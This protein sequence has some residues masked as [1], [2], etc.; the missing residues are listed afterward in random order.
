[1]SLEY[2]KAAMNSSSNK[3]EFRTRICACL[4]FAV[5][6]ASNAESL[7]DANAEF[8][9]TSY[10]ESTGSG[11][12]S[13]RHA[14]TIQQ[15]PGMVRF[16][17]PESKGQATL[18]FRYDKSIVW[19]IIPENRLYPGVRKY[20][21][22]ELRNGTGFDSHIDTLM[23]ASAAL[24]KPEELQNLG[25]ET[26]NGFVSTHYQQRDPV[27][28]LTNEFVVT[29]YWISDSGLLIKMTASGPDISST[30]EMKDIQ[31]GKQP[32]YLFV[33]PPGYEKAGH[34]INW[35]VEQKKLD[36]ADRN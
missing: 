22:F 3:N 36:A 25:E 31:L 34:I 27:P 13:Y 7:L 28:W 23:R 21:E 9:A 14:M 19:T 26:V 29:D 30:M 4:L 2:R 12:S 11:A 20:Q 16:Q 32:E 8:S 6:G 5:A 15:A 24:K 18:I 33:P 35:D 17:P 1:M 10:L